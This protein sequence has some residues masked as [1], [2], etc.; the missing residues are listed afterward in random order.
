MPLTITTKSSERVSRARKGRIVRG[1]S[2][3]PRKIEAAAFMV[4]APLEPS[5]R[6]VTQA[7]PRI[8]TCITPRW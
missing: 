1:A 5:R 2:V 6:A 4:S 7:T 3:W 8:T